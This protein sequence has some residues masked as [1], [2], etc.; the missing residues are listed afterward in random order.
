MNAKATVAMTGGCQCG[1]CRFRAAAPLG[2]ASL[3]HCRMCQK[4]FGSFYGP[5][6]SVPELT[7]TRGGPVHFQSS[8]L[9]RRGFCARCGTPLT[10][11]SMEG[12]P[13]VAIGAFD[14]PTAIA[15]VIQHSLE[16]AMPWLDH[17]P[18]L[19]TRTLAEAADVAPYYQAVVS[20]QHPDHDTD[21]GSAGPTARP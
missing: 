10:F 20:R 1:A 8:N 17:V 5:L 14:D 4:A 18:R 2:R 13:E 6:V 15:P 21:G 3:C 9:A 7:W 16:T 12:P 11:E 19:P